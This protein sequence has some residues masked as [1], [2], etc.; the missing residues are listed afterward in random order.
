M[1]LTKKRGVYHAT[2]KTAS[3]K[4][5]TISTRTTDKREARRV[6]KESGIKDLEATAKAGR[7][8]REAIGQIVTGRKLTMLGAVGEYD[9]WM[10]SI[11]R[12]PKTRHNNVTAVNAWLNDMNITTFPPAAIDEPHVGKWIN[13]PKS[14]S[15]ARTRMMNLAAIR[16]FF[17]FMCGKGWSMGNPAQLVEIDY[18]ILSHAQ[19]E[20]TPRE[21]FNKIEVGRLLNH[22]EE[23]G[24]LFWLFAVRA[25]YE[26]GFRLGDICQLEWPCFEKVGKVI[27]HTDK[28][29]KRIEQQI[30]KEL[31]ELVP[32]IPV[33]HPKYLFPEQREML[34]DAKRRCALSMQFKRICEKL[35]IS[36]KSFHSLRHSAASE[37]FAS[38]NKADLLKK[39]GDALSVD[40]VR[41]LLGH[42]EAKTSKGYIH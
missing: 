32:Q 24:N 7:L 34:L 26:H 41:Q 12:A 16:S 4:T 1:T 25:S 31:E 21:P 36:G 28:S 22:L 3:G 33:Q 35:D 40:E 18:S 17:S 39:L 23:S 6:V 20:V 29:N 30:S 5:K 2:I 27:V 8:T 11:G 14:R 13:N 42:T 19:K 37:K 38:V 15:T 9:K 10:Q